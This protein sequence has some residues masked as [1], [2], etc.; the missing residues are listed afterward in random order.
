M[1]RSH[2][3]GIHLILSV[4]ANGAL[5]PRNPDDLITEILVSSFH[6]APKFYLNIMFETFSSLVDDVVDRP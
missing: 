3:I 4:W 1:Q 5:T 2:D 6:A